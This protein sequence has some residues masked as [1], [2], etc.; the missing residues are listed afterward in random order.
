VKKPSAIPGLTTTWKATFPSQ[1]YNLMTARIR[2]RVKVNNDAFGRMEASVIHTHII[3]I[4]AR[5]YG[6]DP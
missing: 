1:M 2:L 5:C 6:Y 4:C 3:F